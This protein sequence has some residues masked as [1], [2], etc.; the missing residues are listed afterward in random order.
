ME[1]DIPRARRWRRTAGR[2][3]AAAVALTGLASACAETDPPTVQEWITATAVPL[4]TG[5]PRAPLDDLAPLRAAIGDAEVVG[6]GESVHGVA[7]ELTLKHRALRVLVEQLGFRSVAWE[8]DWTTGRLINHYITAGVG[9]PDELVGRM[10]PQWQSREVV[11]VLRWLREFNSGRPDKVLFV[12]VEYYLTGQEAYDVVEAHV[13]AAAPGRL[14]EL[15]EHLQAVR[16]ATA[17]VFEHIQAYAAEADKEPYLR[18]AR[19]V[20]DLVLGLPHTHGNRDHDLAAHAARQ[21]VSFY[22]HFDLPEGESHAYRDAHAAEHLIRWQEL[23]GDKIAY[24]AASPHTARA[25]QLR[26]VAP[27]GEMRFRSAGSYL[28]DRW[29]GRYLSIGFLVDGGRA[30]VGGG[31]T[32]DLGEPAEDWFERP[33]GRAGLDRC[34]LDLRA[35]APQS[36]R[37]WLAAPIRTRGPSGPGSYVDGGTASQWFDVIVHEQRAAPAGS[38]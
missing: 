30:S 35:P 3:L 14:D 8:E 26:I 20:R 5:G 4:G 11:D 17:N 29:G 10:S 34:L 16:P 31:Q 7:E 36:V 33:L 2:A 9:D 32:S 28:A 38:L 24:W 12:G 27:D 19:A 6:L 13:A 18:H 37:D 23:T 22:E 15:R 25:P 1:A 21:I